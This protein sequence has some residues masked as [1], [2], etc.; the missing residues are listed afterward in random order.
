MRK[1]ALILISFCFF[2]ACN[3]TTPT[4]PA[5]ARPPVAP[6]TPSVTLTPPVTPAPPIS[7][8][9]TQPGDTLNDWV[10]IAKAGKY[11]E[12]IWFTNDH[13]GVI[14]ND[15][16]IRV[17]T[18]TG[19]SWSSIPNSSYPPLL[20]I[21][22]LDEKNGFVQ[23]FDQLGTTHDGGSTW[24][25]QRLGSVTGMAFQFLSLTLGYYVDYSHG[26]FKTYDDGNTWSNPGYP[27]TS[28][29]FLDSLNGFL[30]YG[31]SMKKTTDGGVHW[32]VLATG[33]TTFPN[34]YY[35]MQF[36]DPQTGYCATHTGLFKT[37]DGG[38]T[39]INSLAYNANPPGLSAYIIP[40]FLDALNGYCL[41]DHTIYK[42]T[43]GGINWTLSCKLGN[44]YFSCIHFLDMHT[45]WAGTQ[46][47]LILRLRE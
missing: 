2:L 25:F 41:M 32:Q 19:N 28:F 3:K 30:L 34:D 35:R 1:I 23:G 9:L 36:I 17:S 13:T 47:G 31:G 16:L 18:D 22:F 20:N 46:G 21:Q 8:L 29:Y 26:M 14:S 33:L 45:G 37:S 44:D 7:P 43:D 15:T 38:I 42:T 5:V 27:A 10:K 4:P 6:V 24:S 11:V 40:Y 12:D 39:W